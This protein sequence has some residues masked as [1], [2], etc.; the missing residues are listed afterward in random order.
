MVIS[1]TILYHAPSLLEA[2]I[3]E[4][5]AER[6]L[7]RQQ[8]SSLQVSKEQSLYQAIFLAWTTAS[9]PTSLTR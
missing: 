1:A 2:N 6:Q 3:D 9:K 5:Q 4:F 7:Q 8:M